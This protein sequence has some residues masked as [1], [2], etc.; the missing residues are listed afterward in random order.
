MKRA[1]IVGTGRALPEKV[2]TNAD[3]ER[4]VD[5]SDEWITGRTGIKERR[6][7]SDEEAASISRSPATIRLKRVARIV[8]WKSSSSAPTY[9]SWA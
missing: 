5:T 1:R 2:L 7:A 3:F 8:V 4:M 6:I 9:R